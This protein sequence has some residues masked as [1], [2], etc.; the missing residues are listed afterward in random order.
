MTIFALLK[1]LCRRGVVYAD[2]FTPWPIDSE[3]RKIKGCNEN[4]EL[5]QDGGPVVQFQINN[6]D[7]TTTKKRF[8]NGLLGIFSTK[9]LARQSS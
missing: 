2:T 1:V 4:S 7:N 9:M 5:I 8:I 6:R 3:W